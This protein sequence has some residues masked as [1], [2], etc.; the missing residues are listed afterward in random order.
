MLRFRQTEDET[1]TAV[2][3]ASHSR[4][5]ISPV[6]D[7]LNFTVS[8]HREAGDEDKVKHVNITRS[9][10]SLHKNTENRQ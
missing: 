8:Q 5:G 1:Q 10:T 2:N 6:T 9:N 4:P 3:S 7:T